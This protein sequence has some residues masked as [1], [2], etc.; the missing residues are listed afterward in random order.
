MKILWSLCALAP[1]PW[2]LAWSV[3]SVAFVKKSS[4]TLPAKG[5]KLVFITLEI[6]FWQSYFLYRLV[7]LWRL[8]YKKTLWYQA[9]LSQR[10]P[11]GDRQLPENI[12]HEVSFVK[13]LLCHLQ[14]NLQMAGDSLPQALELTP[15]SGQYL[16]NSFY[17]L[18]YVKWL[19]RF[20][21]FKMIFRIIS[22]W[23]CSYWIL[24]QNKHLKVL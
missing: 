15:I 19:S 2:S 18:G 11:E 4:K 22:G 8:L 14:T 23:I 24:K 1:G 3:C 20:L 21:F 12:T 13:T 16:M 10:I 9:Q 6:W 17:L 7:A 5:A